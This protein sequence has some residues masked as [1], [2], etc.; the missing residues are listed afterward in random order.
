MRIPGAGDFVL[1]V[2]LVEIVSQ[3][4]ATV[5][6]TIGTFSH[7]LSAHAGVRAAARSWPEYADHLVLVE[8]RYGFPPVEVGRGAA[9]V[10][11][12]M[13][14]ARYEMGAAAT[15]LALV[16]GTVAL[17]VRAVRR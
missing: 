15:L 8:R 1:R 3:T 13:R 12:A 11:D 2:G 10:D 4:Q 5:S 14:A 6:P 7:I 17:V 16:A 9:L